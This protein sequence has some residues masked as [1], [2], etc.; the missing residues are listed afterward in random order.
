MFVGDVCM[1][2]WTSAACRRRKGCRRAGRWA[3]PA[4]ERAPGVP[5]VPE[6]RRPFV[7]RQR[8][9]PFR[10]SRQEGRPDPSRS[11]RIKIPRTIHLWG[12]ACFIA[13]PRRLP[14][15]SGA[16]ATMSGSRSPFP[17]VAHRHFSA[18]TGSRSPHPAGVGPCRPGRPSRPGRGPLACLSRDSSPRRL[19]A[20]RKPPWLGRREAGHVGTWVGDVPRGLRTQVGPADALGV[21]GE[22]EGRSA[23]GRARRP[24]RSSTP[25]GQ[26][27]VPA[28]PLGAA[29]YHFCI[30]HWIAHWSSSAASPAA[31]FGVDSMALPSFCRSHL[32]NI[33]HVLGPASS[34]HSP[35]LTVSTRR[36]KQK[37]CECNIHDIPAVLPGLI[38]IV[39]SISGL[40]CCVCTM[41]A[42]GNPFPVKKRRHP[43]GSCGSRCQP[44]RQAIDLLPRPAASPH[45]IAYVAATTHSMDRLSCH[46]VCRPCSG[47]ISWR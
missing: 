45:T 13:R 21:Q 4:L 20:D 46:S 9:C 10:R 17:C 15:Y 19:Q 2:G 30:T 27:F 34:S 37:C 26:A 28:A 22:T 16:S 11:P 24:D 39:L 44:D 7:R 31:A 8:T 36:V 41:F 5:G 35:I 38:E 32:Q 12:E 29:S 6:Q 23:R 42:P 33:V 25:V 47:Q 40:K 43:G 18:F 1:Q 14:N 3:G